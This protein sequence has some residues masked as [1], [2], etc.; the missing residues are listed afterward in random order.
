MCGDYFD[1]L[2]DRR[3]YYIQKGVKVRGR[4]LLVVHVI[5]GTSDS[6]SH[7]HVGEV[8][9]RLFRAAGNGETGFFRSESFL[10]TLLFFSS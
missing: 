6:Q 7:G 5:V 3:S 2:S 1:P 8:G 4:L 10:L 9:S